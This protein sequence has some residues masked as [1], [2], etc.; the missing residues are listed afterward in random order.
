MEHI[1]DAGVVQL[2]VRLQQGD[3]HG[4]FATL[5]GPILVQLLQEVFVLVLCGGAVVLIFHFEHDR[6]DLR[7]RLVEVAKNVVALAVV[8]GKSIL[9]QLLSNCLDNFLIKFNH[10]SR[11]SQRDS[12]SSML[13]M[14]SILFF[15]IWAA[16]N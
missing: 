15:D 8:F 6:N 1:H 7:A 10:K 11:K 4:I 14:V 3:Q 2:T 13:L 12:L 16:K 5:F 9:P